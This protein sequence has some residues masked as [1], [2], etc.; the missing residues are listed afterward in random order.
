MV[1][2]VAGSPSRKTIAPDSAKTSVP[3]VA[4]HSYSAS[5]RS[6]RGLIFFSA[7]TSSGTRA[8]SWGA[9]YGGGTVLKPGI[10]AWVVMAPRGV[11]FDLSRCG[12]VAGRGILRW[13]ERLGLFLALWFRPHLVLV[14][15]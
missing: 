6:W 11:A 15:G 5:S 14:H 10:V 9:R 13:R 4:N 8:G 7:S 3:W 2:L 1:I 12:V